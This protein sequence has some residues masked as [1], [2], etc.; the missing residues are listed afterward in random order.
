MC[1]IHYTCNC[2]LTDE[3]SNTVEIISRKKY[4][5][6]GNDLLSKGW[7]LPDYTETKSSVSRNV[8][9]SKRGFERSHFWQCEWVKIFF[10]LTKPSTRKFGR[11]LFEWLSNGR[12][13]KKRTVIGSDRMGLFFSTHRIKE[14]L[15][16]TIKLLIKEK[17]MVNRYFEFEVKSNDSPSFRF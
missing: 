5:Y 9:P 11:C 16:F 8:F 2:T 15:N 7:T 4:C 10:F 12:Q 6:V 3:D 17:L 1:T 14:K 13:E